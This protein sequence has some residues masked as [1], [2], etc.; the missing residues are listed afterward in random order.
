MEWTT[1]LDELILTIKL[2]IFDDLE[3]DTVQTRAL[4]D[5]RPAN[6]FTMLAVDSPAPTV[7]PHRP[8]NQL[9]AVRMVLSSS[10]NV[11][12][13]SPRSQTDLVL[14]LLAPATGTHVVLPS[15]A[16]WINPRYPR[17]SPGQ[18]PAALKDQKCR[19]CTAENT[20]LPRAR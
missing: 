5:D 6:R 16:N 13:L 8:S 11:R 1:T 4:Y 12:L 7:L 9:C 20:K 14:N 2:P 10:V 3:A 18:A 15:H 19:P 17:P